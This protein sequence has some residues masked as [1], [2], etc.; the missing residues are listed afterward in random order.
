MNIYTGANVI[1]TELTVEEALELIQNLAK[2][3]NSFTKYKLGNATAV[4]IENDGAGYG[5]LLNF[6]LVKYETDN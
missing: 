5:R 3:V 2:A 4:A 1:H 6:A